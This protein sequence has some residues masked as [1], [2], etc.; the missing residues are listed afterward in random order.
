MVV[1]YQ[2]DRGCKPMAHY[3]QDSAESG[4]EHCCCDKVHFAGPGAESQL[5]DYL[6]QRQE[7]SE[8]G[9]LPYAL[10]VTEGKAPWGG[11]R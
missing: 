9:G 11:A 4:H 2:C 1:G 6:D 8:D 7:Y 10:H 3:Y 5:R